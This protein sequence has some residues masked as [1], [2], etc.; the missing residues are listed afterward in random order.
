M[1]EGKVAFCRRVIL[2]VDKMAGEKYNVNHVFW[3]SIGG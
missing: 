1:L 2:M 3:W